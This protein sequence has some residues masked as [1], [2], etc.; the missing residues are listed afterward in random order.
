L[1]DLDF[2]KSCESKMGTTWEEEWDQW[3]GKR[4]QKGR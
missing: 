1:W 4:Q 3:D 2:L